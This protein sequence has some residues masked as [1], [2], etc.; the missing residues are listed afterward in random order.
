MAKR[1]FYDPDRGPD[2]YEITIGD[3]G[4]TGI[5][6]VSLVIDPAIEEKGMF[7]SKEE[8]ED[9]QFKSIEY[10]QMV[11]GPAMIPKKKI[12]RK[13][14]NG[15]PYFVFFSEETICK[16]VDKFNSENNN[17]SINIDHTNEMVDGF[18][19]Q[20]WI[21]ADPVYDKSKYYGYNLPKGSWFIECKIND[22]KFF[23][24]KVINENRF[25]FSIEGLLGQTKVEHSKQEDFSS[26]I[27]KLSDE[28]LLKIINS[29]N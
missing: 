4:M 26:L 16:L 28:E 2:L 29:L 17:K 21:V 27:D 5:R 24:D 20:S 11:V 9:Y 8:I 6:L 13:D 19:Q 10:K 25:S 23:K 22:P 3:D 12:L 18:I 15:D 7:F 14:D 1:K